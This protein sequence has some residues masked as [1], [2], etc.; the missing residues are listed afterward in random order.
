MTLR[1]QERLRQYK[2]KAGKPELLDFDEACSV[3][4]AALS[5]AFDTW[6]KDGDDDAFWSEVL[7]WTEVLKDAAQDAMSARIT[8]RSAQA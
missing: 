2:R 8:A 6:W 7:H 3:A 4:D 1:N 5:D